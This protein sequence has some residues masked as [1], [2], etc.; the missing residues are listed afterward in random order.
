MFYTVKNQLLIS[1]PPCL[2]ASVLKF[3][4]VVISLFLC[5]VV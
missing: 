4:L 5:R 1:V 2:C 3:I